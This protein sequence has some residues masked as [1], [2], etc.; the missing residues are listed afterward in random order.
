MAEVKTWRSARIHHIINKLKPTKNGE[1]RRQK[2][3]REFSVVFIKRHTHCKRARFAALK[4][5][6][7]AHG[8]DHKQIDSLGKVRRE[9]TQRKAA[10]IYEFAALLRI[11]ATMFVG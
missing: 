9:A 8:K 6:A 1:T 3:A 11:I 7:T 2:S 10:Q 4:I 5:A